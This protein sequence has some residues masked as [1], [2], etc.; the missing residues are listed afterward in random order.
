V[1]NRVNAASQNSQVQKSNSNEALFIALGCLVFLV[2]AAMAYF[3]HCQWT[4]RRQGAKKERAESIN[5]E[6]RDSRLT[7]GVEKRYELAHQRP[8]T[9]L[10]SRYSARELDGKAVEALRRE[11]IQR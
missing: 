10:P 9:E 8:A 7:L 2:F 6:L 1:T 11:S 4:R 3:L 5:T